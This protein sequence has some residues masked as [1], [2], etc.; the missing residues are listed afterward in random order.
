MRE[1]LQSFA[2][3]VIGGC[4]NFLDAR[5]VVA[6]HDD[7]EIGEAATVDFSTVVPEKSDREQATLARLF[8]SHHD[9]ARSSTGGDADCNI[10]RPRLS[11]ELAQE[12]N[13]GADI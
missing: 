1:H 2:D 13:L 10:F 9:V 7:G 6:A 3:D 5:D 4:L 8:Q 12:N 11:N